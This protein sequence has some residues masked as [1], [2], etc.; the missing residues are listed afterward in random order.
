MENQTE[1]SKEYALENIITASVQI[2]G[3]KVVRNSFL[4]E[5]F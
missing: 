5:A 3:V 1:N 2:P 4:N